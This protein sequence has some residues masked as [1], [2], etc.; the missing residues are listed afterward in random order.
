MSFDLL[1]PLPDGT[2]VLEASAGTGKTY[3]IAALATR[4]VAEA[5]IPLSQLMLVTFGRAATQEL[6]ERTR[7]RLASAAR[8]L[9]DFAAAR[10]SSDDVLRHLAT[11]SDEDVAERRRRLMVALSD[12]DAATITTTHS[13]CQRMLDG[14]GIAGDRE[15][16][17]R[18]VETVDDVVT[19]VAADLY[20]QSYAGHAGPA[21]HLSPAA[22][23]E[24][25]REAVSD[26]QAQLA[27]SDQ[28]LETEVGQR[29]ALATAARVEVDRRKRAAGVRDFDD[30]LILLRDALAHPEHGA[31]SCA[32]VR[33]R[34]RVVLVDEFQDTDPVQWEVLRRA[35]AGQTTL[36][37]IGDPKQAIYAFRGAEVL[38]YLDA[39]RL[40]DRHETLG[41]NWR[42]DAGLLRALEHLYG[43]AA[44]GHP[45]IVVH[46]VAA[47][48][49]DTRLT[50][51]ERRASVHDHGENGGDERRASVHDHGED[52]GWAPLRVRWL[53]RSGS[54]PLG[55]TG[56]PVVGALRERVAADL[57]DELVQLLTSGA[58]LAGAPV[59]PGD[60]AVLV[61]N[62]RHVEA[63]RQAL[64]AAGIPSVV[65]GS[66]SVFETPAATEWLWFLHALEQPQ[67]IG[68]VRLAALSSL[69]GRTADTLDDRATTET[70]LLLRELGRLFDE[71]GFAAGFERLAARTDLDARL[72]SRTGGER[73]LTDLRHVA[74]LLNRAAVEESLGLTALVGWLTERIAD[75]AAGSA[76]DRS[77]RL[78]SDAAAVHIVTVHT[79]KGL[80]FPITYVPFGWDGAKNPNP[81]SLLLHD[82][83]GRRIRD[84][85][86]KQSPGYGLRKSQSELE[87][88]GEELRLLYVALTRAQSQVV[89][90]WAPSAGTSGSPLHR[91]LFGRTPEDVE[92]AL[93]QS[94]PADSRLGDR[95]A[96]WATA[97]EVSVQQVG[98]ARGLRWTP[99]TDNPPALDVARFHRS[100]DLLWRR[101]SYSALTAAAHA[102]SGI[103]TSDSGIGSSEVTGG[104][105]GAGVGSEP[106][107]PIMD[108]EP[109][110]RSMVDAVAGGAPSTM[111]ALPSGPV[112]GTLVHEVF[113]LVDTAAPVFEDELRRRCEEVV[114]LRLSSIDPTELAA[115]LLPV[116]RTPLRLAGEGSPA[117]EL[118]PTLAA[119][120]PHNRLAELDFEMP[121]AGGDQPGADQVMLTHV[122][123]LLRKHLSDDDP[124]AGY[125]DLLDQVEAPP[126]RGFL[127][128]SID[129]VL[130]LPGPRYVVVDYKT[131][132]LGRGDLT[133]LNYT[134]DALVEEMLH[135]HYPLQALLY[136]V[137]LH[138]YLRWRQPG[139]DP[140]QHLG[141]IAYLFVR[142]MVG[143]QTPPGC[144]VFDWQPPV[145]LIPALSDLL[146]G[147]GAPA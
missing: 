73:R 48:T 135:A 131:N 103:G 92:P 52:G 94:V 126:L 101:T 121:L 129:A 119:I 27:P 75:P 10:L 132:R 57:A 114:A 38:S 71:A 139:Y 123:A 1:G 78:E 140:A 99:P 7:Q 34:Y 67:R 56:F 102:G 42:S 19:E 108:D 5:N 80:E 18:I 23:V 115:A 127:S 110:Q 31:E 66:T 74:Q 79:S 117:E 90:W 65:A 16:G 61:R 133:V 77:R 145:A 116:F 97:D 111:N 9:N 141:P 142:G 83:D 112:F 122:A 104:L 146:A 76:A 147:T 85:G 21:P 128:G 69:V 96:G 144:G 91:L 109:A 33:E 130:R 6:R 13:F 22:A 29:V 41:T 55:K 35:F 17:A 124:L 2:V 3:A 120:L 47:A 24:I 105:D 72:L 43:G 89:L 26:R 45:D 40:A 134:R 58:Q 93:R 98:A 25:A 49:A 138:R 54:G 125:P 137:A 68:P 70:S 51:P 82:R 39:V 11:G 100:I 44:L 46:P 107:Q 8:G 53:D 37:L 88:A 4:Y 143:P 15:P 14:L 136:G 64:D 87:E 86:G 81:S 118:A 63:V 95:F 59:Q 106:E 84:I 113:E 36:V 50:M 20:L 62:R 28:P 30:L 12:F 32:R 60:V